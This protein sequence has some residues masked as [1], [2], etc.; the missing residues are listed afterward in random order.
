MS[1]TLPSGREAA[2]QILLLVLLLTVVLVSQT[3]LLVPLQKLPSEIFGGDLY[4]QMG[5]IRSIRDSGN[6]L[7][8]CSTSDALPG[9]LPFYGTLVAL[10]SRVSGLDVF[11]SM[12]LM[13][14]VLK[15]LGV[16]ALYG[17]VARIFDRW[18]GI[19]IGALSYAAHPALL[20]HY[21]EFAAQI[22]VPVYLLALYLFLSEHTTRRALFLGGVLMV[23]G[24]SHA[25]VFIGCMA[26]F[27]LASTL[28]FLAKAR[29]S[30]PGREIRRLWMPVALVFLCTLLTLGYWYKPIFI[31]HGRTSAHYTEWNG[32]P[33]LDTLSA[34]LDQALSFLR[35]QWNFD[36]LP[37]AIISLL[38]ALGMA[39]ALARWREPK[40]RTWL[41][42]TGVTLAY[43]FH[44][45]VTQPLL[46]VNFV[47]ERVAST[48][49]SGARWLLVA[50]PLGALLGAPRS[51]RTR[52][53]FLAI[54]V[55][56]VLGI[57]ASEMRSLVRQ[58]PYAVARM[59]LAPIFTSLQDFVRRNTDVDDV[60]LSANELSFAL[61]ALTG[62]KVMV[63]RRAQNDAF[64]DMDVRNK[65]AALILYGNDVDQKRELIRRYGI[66]YQLWMDHW[67]KTEYRAT[68]SGEGLYYV[69]P[70]LYFENPAYDQE[71][72]RAGVA[73]L[74]V[75]GWVDPALRSP[76]VK[77]LPL[78][79]VSPANYRND[80]TPWRDNLDPFLER[81]WSYEEGGRLKAA[82]Y[83]VK[84]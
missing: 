49:W 33:T 34:R 29:A 20:A 50:L 42:I 73:I 27:L 62:R 43:V 60:F 16:L 12:L 68:P 28:L 31:Y 37:G 7:A 58:R 81:I 13:G 82:I 67:I 76:G 83:R 10:F 8:S 40:A 74:H 66:R 70:L 54:M 59:P 23:A 79:L 65:D 3:L 19:A 69:D 17:L 9:Y 2:L 45:F 22:V 11:P 55:F 72:S 4:Y 5:C 77:Q 57:A 75:E 35:S 56:A 30:S 6:P 63:T 52:A 36:S 71:L 41:M 26:I 15:A 80:V 38:L 24:Y 21:T 64:I 32:G 18:T 78:S 39:M 48:L 51:S 44:P 25:V 14:V 47:P 46:G 53:L 1:P 84:P 61:S